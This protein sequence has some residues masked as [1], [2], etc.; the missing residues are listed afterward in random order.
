MWEI[1]RLCRSEPT[2]VFQGGAYNENYF[3]AHSGCLVENQLSPKVS[4]KL[5]KRSWS[6]CRCFSENISKQSRNCGLSTP[7]VLCVVWVMI[8]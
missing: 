4:V 8:P 1:R 2:E 7:R 3:L 5:G 6:H